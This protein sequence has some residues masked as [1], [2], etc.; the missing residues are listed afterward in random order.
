MRGSK[1]LHF[2][3]CLI[4]ALQFLSQILFTLETSMKHIARAYIQATVFVDDETEN[5]NKRE[6]FWDGEM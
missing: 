4:G 5:S 1:S 6:K 3:A 2:P